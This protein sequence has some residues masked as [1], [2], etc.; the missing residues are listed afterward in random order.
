MA[1]SA[2]PFFFGR[3]EHEKTPTI[4][5]PD[6]MP[7]W[8]KEKPIRFEGPRGSG[9]SSMLRSL[10]WE[11]AWHVSPV[12]VV[13]SERTK[14]FL[15][16][17]TH[18]GVYAK[19]EQLDVPYWN[20]W[21]V[22]EDCRQRY[23]G[24]YLEFMYLGL[25][26]KALEGIQRK[27]EELLS[28]A[29]AETQFITDLLAECFSAASKP[30]L[31]NRTFSSLGE[32]VTDIA[33]GIRQLVFQNAPQSVLQET[34]QVVGPG[35]LVESFG[36]AFQNAYLQLTDWVFLI[37]LDDCNFLTKW[38]TRV[39]NAAVAISQQPIAYKLSSLTG[40]Y[41]TL[42]TLINNRP[43]MADDIEPVYLP[44][45]SPFAPEGSHSERD[46]EYLGFVEGVC[47]AR[48]EEQY[49]KGY[50]KKF[51]FTNCLG[52]FDIE[53]LL[54]D[55][56]T[57][58]ESSNAQTLLTLAKQMAGSKK[59]KSITAAWLSQK[60]VRDELQDTSVDGIVNKRRIRQLSS[61]YQKKWN[62]VAAVA[63]CQEYGFEF[64][65]CG[66]T[67]ILHLTGGS[68][69]EML[70]VMSAIW[71]EANDDIDS[72]VGETPLNAAIQRRGILKAS[73][74]RF[75]V[76]SELPI[77][78]SEI[79]L[80]DVCCRLGTLFQKCQSYPYIL[81]TPET[82]SIRVITKTIGKDE[83]LTDAFSKAVF[84]GT[85]VTREDNE[86]TIIGLHPLLSPK[87]GICFRNPFYY[88]ERISPEQLRALFLGTNAEAN[89]AEAEILK[90]RLKRY[91]QRHLQNSGSSEGVTTGLRQT[92]FDIDP[93]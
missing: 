3:S 82:A 35:S 74:G 73:N 48:I 67:T 32:V 70:R 78:D 22:S 5:V 36:K 30:N 27:D 14:A 51:S 83:K 59:K 66:Y 84:T 2:N 61:K 50:A 54:E 80:K 85:F 56:F 53:R 7:E 91:E 60:E 63:I 57:T 81:T 33:R 42:D 46:K 75:N 76:I 49:G 11:V 47:R 15:K 65:Y 21:E 6:N 16:K 8:A 37:L 52:P 62:H 26:L 29:R 23:F 19:V 17:Q 93:E 77:S 25:L 24:T 4:F 68:I 55:K 92:M 40:M 89:Q 9:K 1:T 41:P 58:S 44:A 72:F 90:A 86:D 13:G 34:Y 45:K 64:P 18:V 43:L 38:Q 10:T 69:R 39:V 88:P 79:N 12:T 31:L 28:D 71:N 20:A 87:F